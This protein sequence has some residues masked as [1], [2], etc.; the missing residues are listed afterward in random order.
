MNEKETGHLNK[1]KSAVSHYYAS[2]PL[3][4]VFMVF[5]LKWASIGALVTRF[6]IFLLKRA[7]IV[8]LVTVFMVL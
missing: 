8:A 4:T 6:L 3:V 1:S 2:R 7:S 5:S